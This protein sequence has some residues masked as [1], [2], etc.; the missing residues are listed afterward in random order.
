MPQNTQNVVQPCGGALVLQCWIK[1]NESSQLAQYSIDGTAVLKRTSITH[2]PC[3]HAGLWKLA[4]SVGAAE[5]R[6]RGCKDALS[7]SVLHRKKRKLSW[8]S[9]HAESFIL[10]CLHFKMTERSRNV[11]LARANCDE[12]W[13]KL[14]GLSWMPI[15]THLQSVNCTTKHSVF[16]RLLAGWSSLRFADV[17]KLS[18]KVVRVFILYRCFRTNW[19]V[20]NSQPETPHRGWESVMDIFLSEWIEKCLLRS[21]GNSW[22]SMKH[23]FILRILWKTVN[24]K[25]ACF[26]FVFCSISSAWIEWQLFDSHLFLKYPFYLC[27]SVGLWRVDRVRL[28]VATAKWAGSEGTRMSAA[29]SLRRPGCRSTLFWRVSTIS[30]SDSHNA[31][32]LIIQL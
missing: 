10:G 17:S 21:V 12:M 16:A 5:G 22:Q 14:K 32:A 19:L 15:Q 7:V 6:F 24:K 20:L 27:H 2:P 13:L 1:T 9:R 26:F 8:Q 30:G 4:P 18:T 23:D 28:R 29:S 3:R 25:E 31:G 11:Q